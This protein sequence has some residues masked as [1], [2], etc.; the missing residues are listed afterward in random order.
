MASGAG[1]TVLTA[2]L[3]LTPRVRDLDADL[4]QWV[5]RLPGSDPAGSGAGP[6]GLRG[7]ALLGQRGVTLPVLLAAALWR[8]R[9]SRSIRPVRTVL[10]GLLL[11]AGA[12]AGMKYGLGR[13]APASGT[14]GLWLGGQ[15]FPSGHTANAVLTAGL[16]VRLVRRPRGP[17]RLATTVLA[18]AVAGLVAGAAV[19]LLDYH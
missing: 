19:L 11:L 14:D 2:L 5:L 13:P 4:R 6:L 17:D 16:L 1:L 18:G 8:A 9:M 3:V 15:S 10:T 7:A 12:G